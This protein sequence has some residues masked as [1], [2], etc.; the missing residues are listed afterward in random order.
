MCHETTQNGQWTKIFIISTTSGW[1]N[2]EKNMLNFSGYHMTSLKM[3]TKSCVT[4]CVSCF[5]LQWRNNGCNGISNHQPH[6]CLLSHLFKRRPK[7]TSKLHV[8][9]LCVGNSPV[10]GEFP[11]QRASNIKNVSMMSSWFKMATKSCVASCVSCVHGEGHSKATSQ[12]TNGAAAYLL[13]S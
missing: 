9:G 1:L 12:W 2:E 13:L 8:T 7:E 11:A 10:T 6:H 4:S 5:P 3:A